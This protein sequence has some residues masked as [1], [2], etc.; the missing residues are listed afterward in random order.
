MVAEGLPD[1]DATATGAAEAC[2]EID[3]IVFTHQY[4]IDCGLR[5]RDSSAGRRRTQTLEPEPEPE[6]EHEPEPIAEEVAVTVT[7]AA[8]HVTTREVNG[9]TVR[10][11]VRQRTANI[12]CVGPMRLQLRPP[13]DQT[14]AARWAF[15]NFSVFTKGPGLHQALVN[16]FADRDILDV[17][18]EPAC[19]R[20][21]R[22]T[23]HTVAPNEIKSITAGRNEE[24]LFSIGPL[25]K[26]ATP[27]TGRSQCTETHNFQRLLVFATCP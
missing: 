3:E 25:T 2:A 16:N 15:S 5:G 24:P 17:P 14:A 18:P 7:L 22:A 9:D 21:S 4:T 23:H 6:P 27:N 13:V 11:H 12:P 1:N 26:Q 19:P 8:E 20:F 10:T